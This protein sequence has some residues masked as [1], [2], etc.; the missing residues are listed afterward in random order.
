MNITRTVALVFCALFLLLS[1]TACYQIPGAGESTTQSTDTANSTAAATPQRFY[2]PYSQGDTLDPAKCKSLMNR[3]V[4]PL[5]YE[6]LYRVDGSYKPVPCLAAQSNQETALTLAVDIRNTAF[7]D[8]SAVTP[9]DV[10][11]SFQSAKKSAL[12]AQKLTRVKS[13]AVRG[14]SIVFQLTEPDPYLT[15]S[16]DFAIFRARKD[17]LPLGSGRYVV[18][19]KKNSTVLTKNP[20]Y[21]D[22]NPALKELTLV[23]ITDSSTLLN[24]MNIGTVSYAYHELGGGTVPRVNG[25]KLDVPMNNLIYLGMRSGNAI[26]AEKKLRQA[27]N[28][29]LDRATIAEHA[30]QN[31]ALPAANLFHPN[32]YGLSGMANHTKANT[33]A[34]E[35]LL[36]ECGM[37]AQKRKS[38]VLTLLVN[39]DNAF[40]LQ[41]AQTVASQFYAA[42]IQVNVDAKKAKDYRGALEAGKYDLYIGE[43]RLTPNM[44]L[45]P[46]LKKGGAAAFGVSQQNAMAAAYP[47]FCAGELDLAAFLKSYADDPALLSL[48][49]RNALCA[50]STALSCPAQLQEGDIFAQMEQ[51]KFTE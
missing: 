36:K 37:T 23:D 43:I 10:V 49:Y 30:F 11:A 1:V 4:L 28:L 20:A 7:S 16:L 15:A 12:Y 47:K 40:Q 24:C 31:H 27:L 17:Q 39:K 32:W 5:L 26:L 46:L 6:S 13:A 50:V 22:F 19:E 14:S 45:N 3:Q 35:K 33:Q 38:F 21:A 34:A 42:G 9:A 8:G 29:L 2:L 44:N 25:A 18:Q 51:W 48:C 41:T